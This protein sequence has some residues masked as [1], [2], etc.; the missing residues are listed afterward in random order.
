MKLTLS[1]SKVSK[2]NIM[3]FGWF[4]AREAK[5][6]GVSLA[7]FYMERIPL[8]TKPGRS[9]GKTKETEVLHKMALQIAQFTQNHKMNFYKKAQFGNAFRWALVDAGYDA[10]E[11]DEVTNYLLLRF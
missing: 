11:A 6:F 1:D 10:A 3:L 4:N 9:K 2:G 7:R 5:D 8:V